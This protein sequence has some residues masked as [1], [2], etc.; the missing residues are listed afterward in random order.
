MS[1]TTVIIR[2]TIM[3]YKKGWSI[4][5][6]VFLLAGHLCGNKKEV[7]ESELDKLKKMPHRKVYDVM[8]W[9]YYDLDHKQQQIFLDLVY[10]ITTRKITRFLWSLNMKFFVVH[11]VISASDLKLLLKDGENDNSVVADLERLKD[12]ALITFSKDNFVSMRDSLQEMA[13]EI[14]RREFIANP[15]SH[16]RLWDPD[17]IYD[18]LKNDKVRA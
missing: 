14:V 4:M 2:A 5:P 9:S 13:W 1:L 7:W 10:H 3:S 12:R 16:S 8:I 15:R 18:T 17:D 11:K 6:K